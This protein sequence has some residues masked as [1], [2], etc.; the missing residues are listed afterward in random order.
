MAEEL[1]MSLVGGG[2]GL[3]GQALGN[4]IGLGQGEA[5]AEEL[6]KFNLQLQKNL[7]DYTNYENQVKHM[8]NAGLNV[9]LMYGKGG[10]GGA[11]ASIAGGSAQKVSDQSFTQ[12]MAMMQQAQLNKAQI[13]NINADTKKKEVEANKLAGVD[14]EVGRA[15]IANLLQGV[16]NQKAQEVLTQVQ[17]RIGNAEAN[18]KEMSIDSS[19]RY[20]KGLADYQEKEVE[21]L[22]YDNYVSKN[23]ADTKINMANAELVKVYL[24]NALTKAQTDNT[25]QM[26]EESKQRILQKWSEVSQGWHNVKS[27]E[28]KAQ[29]DKFIAELK[30]EY[31]AAFDVV[32]KGA[33]TIVNGLTD[34][35]NYLFGT[36]RHKAEYKKVK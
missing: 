16:E 23:T 2:L 30:A 28:L 9:G 6:A 12:G 25:I 35:M 11:T 20:L 34:F 32:G 1:G 4:A 15:Q 7:W 33:D 31:P 5:S 3:A 18:I 36:E 17:T 19:V 14:T 13:E 10:G 24:E 8:K 29:T 27:N 26:T 22:T 21:R